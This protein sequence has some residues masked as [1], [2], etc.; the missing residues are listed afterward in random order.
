M[1]PFLLEDNPF[2]IVKEPVGYV[3]DQELGAHVSRLLKVHLDGK[4]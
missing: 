1:C 3:Y 4:F 2:K